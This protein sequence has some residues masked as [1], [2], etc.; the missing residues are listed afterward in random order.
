[1]SHEGDKLGCCPR[2]EKPPDCRLSPTRGREQFPRSA[3]ATTH[4]SFLHMHL[5]E[6]TRSTGAAQA[7]LVLPE[8]QRSPSN[9]NAAA[10]ETSFHGWPRPR[11]GCARQPSSRR[12]VPTPAIPSERRGLQVG[13]SPNVSISSGVVTLSAAQTGNVGVGD[14]TDYDSDKR[15]IYIDSVLLL[16]GHPALRIR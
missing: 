4:S 5:G 7:L 9:D 16:L 6:K 8:T 10:P 13:L 14:E 3:S 15:K 11:C 2:A 1:M 12:Q